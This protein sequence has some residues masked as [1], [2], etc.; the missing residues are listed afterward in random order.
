MSERNNAKIKRASYTAEFKLQVIRKAEETGNRKAGRLFGISETNVRIWRKNK[1]VLLKTDKNRRANRGKIASWQ[2]LEEALFQWLVHNRDSKTR[3]S[4]TDILE[5]SRSLADE[6]D[7]KNFGGK[8]QWCLRFLQRKNLR[9]C[10]GIIYDE[11][12]PADW[13]EKAKSFLQKLEEAIVKFHYGI[14]DI[15]A[16]GEVCMCIDYF[17]SA[18]PNCSTVSKSK[19]SF[20][21]VL[22]CSA[23][24]VKLKPLIIFRT[25]DNPFGEEFPDGVEVEANIKGC[26]DAFVMSEWFDIVWRGRKENLPPNGVLIVDSKKD[27]FLS[28]MTDVRQEACAEIMSIPEGMTSKL[29]P[30]D[31]NVAKYFESVLNFLLEKQMAVCASNKPNLTEIAEA[32]RK[33][34]S[35]VSSRRIKQA[36]IYS[37]IVASKQRQDDK[38]CNDCEL[39]TISKDIYVEEMFLSDSDEFEFDSIA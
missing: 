13:E 30:L 37:G 39:G 20:S 35:S 23:D 3:I 22:A 31:F 2:Y 24:G 17:K 18:S 15:I 7:V 6:M 4:M 29:Q 32:V 16:M 8:K 9:L 5:K 21:I 10:D 1:E 11:N 36:F 28:K 12:I 19:L 27:H 14:C 33:A 26:L 38:S 34:W 25:K